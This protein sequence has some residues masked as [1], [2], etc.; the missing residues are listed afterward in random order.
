MYAALKFYAFISLCDVKLVWTVCRSDKHARTQGGTF[1]YIFSISWQNI[2]SHD[3]FA[4][5]YRAEWS[6]LAHL[7]K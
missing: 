4:D 3:I 2:Y 5:R 6:F 1:S 7:Q